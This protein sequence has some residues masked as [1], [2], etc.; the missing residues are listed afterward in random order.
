[1]GPSADTKPKSPY[2]GVFALSRIVSLLTP[3]LFVV[4]LISTIACWFAILAGVVVVVLFAPSVVA[5]VKERKS[6]RRK[7]A[8]GAL[9]LNVVGVAFAGAATLLMMGNVNNACVHLDPESGEG[10]TCF[11]QQ[12]SSST[13]LHN[14]LF[15]QEGV[16]S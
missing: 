6:E 10:I 13:G 9:A 5:A 3:I 2:K 8:F 15:G 12:Y 7:L 1:M 14:L 4:S 16:R 11:N